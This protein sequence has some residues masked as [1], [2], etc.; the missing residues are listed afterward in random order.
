MSYLLSIVVP[1]KDRYKY[2][3]HLIEL[4]KGF[5]FESVEL[6]V[7]DNTE[8]NKPIMDYLSGLNFPHLKYF[9]CS[10][11]IPISLNADR[12]VLNSSGEYVC[13]IGDDDGVLDNIVECVQWMKN[14]QVDALVPAE[15]NYLWPDHF[16][17]QSASK[18][19]LHNNRNNQFSQCAQITDP[20][21]VLSESI[22]NGFLNRGRLP[23]VYHGVVAR[24]VLDKIY[25]KTDSYFPGASPDIANGVA[26]CFYVKKYVR[27]DCPVIISGASREHGGGVNH[28]KNRIAPIDE[29]PFLPPNAKAD[30]ERTLPRLWAGETVWP[31]SAIKALRSMGREDLVAKVNYLKILRSF[32]AAHPRYFREAF[33]VSS[34]PIQLFVTFG[35]DCFR[36]VCRRM[37]RRMVMLVKP[38]FFYRGSNREEIQNIKEAALFIKK[39][40]PDFLPQMDSSK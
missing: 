12:A 2:L 38:N 37:A 5:N 33:A 6:V 3:K 8:D 4:I 15:V 29:V 1:T 25:E 10:E 28:K 14:N 36:R 34:S 32:L 27:L 39:L 31:E 21:Q 23:L 19:F 22:N 24:E 16:L 13:F 7:Q 30:W 11:Q 9:H 26:L 17:K 35:Y 18:V 20:F 40:C